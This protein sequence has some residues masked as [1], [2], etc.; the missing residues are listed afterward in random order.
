MRVKGFRAGE[1]LAREFFGGSFRL[2]HSNL[3]SPSALFRVVTVQQPQVAAQHPGRGGVSTALPLPKA[4]FVCRASTIATPNV[5][6]VRALHYSSAVFSR[7]GAQPPSV[8]GEVGPVQE[9]VNS[10]SI[11][12]WGFLLS[13]GRNSESGRFKVQFAR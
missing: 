11:G 12:D 5:V 1:A 7:N 13:S 10:L 3:E 2:P 6:D 8:T 9:T 4:A